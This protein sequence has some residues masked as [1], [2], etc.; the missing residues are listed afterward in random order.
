MNKINS[1][2]RN[3][4]DNL[5]REP[6]QEIEEHSLPIFNQ[7]SSLVNYSDLRNVSSV[8]TPKNT[9]KTKKRR[10]FKKQTEGSEYDKISPKQIE[11]NRIS[12]SPPTLPDRDIHDKLR[13]CSSSQEIF[14]ES[15]PKNVTQ[16]LNYTSN[17]PNYNSGL[18]RSTSIQPETS[19]PNLSFIRSTSSIFETD[20]VPPI[21][22]K[23]KSFNK[24]LSL[25]NRGKRQYK[26]DLSSETQ[27]SHHKSSF[28][29][30][31]SVVKSL[32][33]LLYHS[34]LPVV[35]KI[36]RGYCVDEVD[37]EPMDKQAITEGDI[38]FIVSLCIK[39]CAILNLVDDGMKISIP[40]DANCK[41]LL[42]PDSG[43]FGNIQCLKIRE[44][45]SLEN[46]PERLRVVKSFQHYQ[47]GTIEVGSILSMVNKDQQN[48]CISCK[49]FDGKRLILSEECD[50]EFS[51][52]LNDQP[53]A[54]N[55]IM[56]ICKHRQR[57]IIKGDLNKGFVKQ[58]INN[59]NG[60]I[61]E[62]VKEDFLFCNEMIQGEG[63][64]KQGRSWCLPIDDEIWVET[65]DE[66]KVID[67][68]YDILSPEGDYDRLDQSFVPKTPNQ[69]F[70]EK[71][72]SNLKIQKKRLEYNVSKLENELMA[73][74]QQINALTS[75]KV[76]FH[77]LTN[78]YRSFNSGE[79]KNT[80]RDIPLNGNPKN[81]NLTTNITFG[82][83]ASMNVTE[84]LEFLE[85][86]NL[87]EY[88]KHFEKEQINGDLFLLLEEDDLVDLNI[89]KRLD[90]KKI[91]RIKELLRSGQSISNYLFQ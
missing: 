33:Q 76:G 51:P 22:P 6:P 5:V 60:I 91:I 67:H 46:I 83:V 10:K 80:H 43:K 68:D 65:I 34:K 29:T 38:L 55:N 27:S 26:K 39:D 25:P 14:S 88:C 2:F 31:R 45:L 70:Y 71:E 20:P 78:D 56:N 17:L 8:C 86:L 4:S 49:I 69:R 40:F 32:S 75:E 63:S 28:D 82:Q 66:I 59:K 87:S 42:L 84:I 79:F 64:L 23:P 90:K 57:V 61:E 1:K 18:T 72:L 21:P 15:S 48:K 77:S 37:D 13:N 7:D 3:S 24:F 73:A 53:L 36:V 9:D 52:Y 12:T 54:M 44:I 62:F 30:E 35:V 16:N 50:G 74:R 47:S 89:L 85:I 41:Y 11:F 81:A 58:Y 19:L